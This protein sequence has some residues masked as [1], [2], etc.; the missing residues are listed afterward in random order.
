MPHSGKKYQLV[1]NGGF[2][3]PEIYNQ[4]IYIFPDINTTIVMQSS[5]AIHFPDRFYYGQQ[6]AT[7]ANLALKE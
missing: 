1:D 5:Y 3:A 7:A 2:A 6:F 4:A